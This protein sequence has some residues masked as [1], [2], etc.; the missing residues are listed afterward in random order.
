MP[1]RLSRLTAS[2][3]SVRLAIALAFADASVAVLALPQIVVRLHT[4]ISHVTWVIT[5][6]NLTLIAGTLLIL[7]FASRVAAR[8]FLVAGLAAFGLASLGSGAASSLTVLII[9]RC[10]QGAGGAVLLCSSLP[11]FAGRD[12]RGLSRLHAWAATA[13]FGAAVGPAAGGVLTQ[14]FDWRAIFFAQA[15]VAALAAVA[16]LAGGSEPQPEGPRPEPA[17][18]EPRTEPAQAAPS[19]SPAPANLALCLLSAGLIGALFLA[20]VLLINVWQ[21]TPLGAAAVLAVIPLTTALTARV[22][23]ER[24]VT[25]SA[26]A[27]AIVLAAG[28][29]VLALIPERELG[30]AVLALALCGVGLGLAFPALTQAALE[31]RGPAVARAARTVAAREGGLVL[32]LVLLT[33]VLVG[34]LTSAPQEATPPITAA[35]VV[36]PGSLVDKF[37]LGA[38]LVA[39]DSH[40]PAS[41]LPNFGPAFRAAAA[42]D[43]SERSG[44]MALES[45]VQTIVQRTVT[46]SFRAPLELCAL[47]SLL[48]LPALAWGYRVRRRG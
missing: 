35:I 5:A 42:G 31:T 41:E 1:A 34:Q 32:G 45:S 11:L 25:G 3:L 38:E 24:D 43:P 28:L 6:Y 39:I 37:R 9:W 14:V 2:D 29:M 48:A 36:G 19:L 33:P 13:A 15:P 17:A 16:A 12:P 18:T 7:P 23:R 22:T 30:W 8:R 4:S 40:T 10:V 44:F 47:L 21:L 46:R 20:T 26:A 27:G